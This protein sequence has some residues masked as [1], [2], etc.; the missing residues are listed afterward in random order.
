MKQHVYSCMMAAMALGAGLP[1]LADPLAGATMT[2]YEA[3]GPRQVELTPPSP[4]A[5]TPMPT[6]TVFTPDG[7][8]GAA[9]EATRPP[10]QGA[11]LKLSTGYRHDRLRF[12]IASDLDGLSTPNLLSELIWDVPAAEIRF[13]GGWTHPSGITAQAHLAYAQAFFDGTVQDSDYLFNDRQGEFSRS[14][15]EAKDSRMLDVSLGGGWRLPL[16]RG[17]TLTPMLGI[18]RYGSLYRMRNGRQVVSDYGWGAPLGAFA[19]LNSHYNAVWNSLWQG[20]EADFRPTEQLALHVGLK[21][22]WFDYRAE[23]DWN[24]RSDFAHPV[25]YRHQGRGRGWE[26]AIG[27]DW[28]IRPGHQITWDLSGRQFRLHNGSDTTYR[29]NG[30]SREMRLNEVIADSWSTRIGYRYAF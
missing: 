10:T 2:V 14:Y 16:G 19:G 27:A 5:P 4:Q 23:A 9:V 29:P 28:R 8:D 21:H 12:S 11:Y 1:T 30:A 18:A 22:H 15:S 24:L 6:L 7:A 3:A 26:A 17:N 20:L 13:D 25:S